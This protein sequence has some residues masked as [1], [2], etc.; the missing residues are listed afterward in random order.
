MKLGLFLMPQA[1]PERTPLETVQF[2]REVVRHGDQL[3]YSEAWI[4]E[5]YST[6]W[7]PVP[8]PDLV[9]AQLIEETEQIVLAPGAHLLPFHH[10][11]GLAHRVAFLDHLAQGR[12]ALGIGS[13]VVPLDQDLFGTI[14]HKP[15]GTQVVK[16]HEMTREALDIMIKIWTAD[17]GFTYE[18]EFWSF[19]RPDFDELQQGP[20]LKP[21]QQPY[22]PLAMAGVSVH[23]ATLAAAG[24]LGARPLSICFGGPRYLPIHWEIYEGAASKAGHGADRGDWGVSSA[25]LVADTDEEA[26]RLAS[27]GEMGRAWEK[28]LI[29]SVKYVDMVEWLPL[30]DTDEPPSDEELTP[31][32]LARNAWPVGS[33]ET[34]AER[35]VNIYETSGGFGTFMAIV[36]DFIDDPA[37]LK[38]SLTLLKE[39]VLPRVE[40]AIKERGPA[41]PVG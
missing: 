36:F 18:G 24:E 1:A 8:C 30:S 14:E 15:D 3:G 7:E 6:A 39:E 38:H 19:V 25:V 9:I 13:G 41:A 17:E 2:T 33:P 35:L 5:H 23:S 34:V 27:T 11:V 26:I 29:P 31:E 10:P 20:W 37:P 16:T 32:W 21:F 22:P 12:Y 28:F 4:G 40:A